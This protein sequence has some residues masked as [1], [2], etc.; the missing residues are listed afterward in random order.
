MS[1][2]RSKPRRARLHN[3][4]EEA[5]AKMAARVR[6]LAEWGCPVDE[7]ASDLKISNESLYRYFRND[8]KDGNLQTRIEL[9]QK[10]IELA[11]AGNTAMLRWLGI[12][13]LGQR[14]RFDEKV[15]SEVNVAIEAPP[16]FVV[17]VVRGGAPQVANGNGDVRQAPSPSSE[18]KP[19]SSLPLLK[20]Q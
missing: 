6:Q 13:L 16:M 10:Q 9:R 19:Q 5:M 14:E 2:M 17:Q 18:K 3:I 8:I 11:K 1:L 12:Q 20:L 7:I 4:S 15:E